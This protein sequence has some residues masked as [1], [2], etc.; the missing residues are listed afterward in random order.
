[1]PSMP[2]AKMT[3]RPAIALRG[4]ESDPKMKPPVRMIPVEAPPS[5]WEKRVQNPRMAATLRLRASR[6]EDKEEAVGHTVA[7]VG[8]VT[9]FTRKVEKTAASVKMDIDALLRREPNWNYFSK[10]LKLVDP[11]GATLTLP[12]IKQL[13]WIVRTFIGFFVQ[14]EE[15]DIK[16]QLMNIDKP[17]GLATMLAKGNILVKGRGLPP[18]CP[19]TFNLKIDGS[20]SIYFNDEGLVNEVVVDAWSFNGRKISLPNLDNSGQDNLSPKDYFA[21]VMWTRKSIFGW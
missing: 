17:D 15:V 16:T 1:M 14:N 5:G 6:E 20:C 9:P 8:E 11:S 3:R 7:S 13:L 19:P 18:P 12:K 2:R 10:D 4:D 21:L